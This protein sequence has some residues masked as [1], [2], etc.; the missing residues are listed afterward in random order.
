MFCNHGLPLEV[1]SDRGPQFAGKYNQ[2][3]S[4]CLRISWNMSTAFYPQ[5]DGQ[6]ERMN[7]IVEDL[8]RHFVSPTMTNWDEL[9]MHAQFAINNAWQESMQNTPFYLNHG[10][11]PRTPSSASLERGRTLPSKSR[12]PASAAF[13]QH[14]QTPIAH[15]KT[16]M[17]NAQQRQKHYY[18]KRHVPSV[19]EVGAEVLL[20]TTDLHLRT[21][22]TR[23]LIPRWVEPFKVLARMGGTAYNL[24]LL[25]CMHQVYTVFH[26]SLIKPYRSDGCTQPPPPPDLVDDCPEWTVEQVLDHRGVKRGRQRKVKLLF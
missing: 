26:V 18:D 5:T 15:A 13:A 9:L 22:G 19:F 12:H 8:L 1:I 25:D 11:H 3:L 14:M 21:T 17:L 16:C 24:D 23:K 10:R 7:R 2:A 6:T 20:A 4:D